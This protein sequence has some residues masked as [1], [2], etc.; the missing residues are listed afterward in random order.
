MDSKS[1]LPESLAKDTIVEAIFE[2]R[3]SNTVEKMELLPGMLFAQVRDQ[4]PESMQLAAASVP[5]Q[6]RQPGPGAP[7]PAVHKLTGPD[8]ALLFSDVSVVLSMHRPYVG[9]NRFRSRIVELLSAL[10]K[11]QALDNVEKIALRYLNIVSEPAGSSGIDGLEIKLELAGIDYL[12]GGLVIRVESRK[13]PY[14]SIVSVRPGALWRSPL[15][16]DEVAG[17][18][19]DIDCQLQLSFEST[20]QLVEDELDGIHQY[21]K[22]LFFGL[23]KDETRAAL[24]RGE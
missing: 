18:M 15:Q 13:A 10:S 12:D 9:W 7:W 11:V 4:Y 6:A 3:Y 2:I 16:N 19:L 1:N 23:L 5:K 8:A 14:N 20:A 17:V 22:E 24:E 21:A